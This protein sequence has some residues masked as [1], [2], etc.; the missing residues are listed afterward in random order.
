MSRIFVEVG[1][2]TYIHFV[3]DIAWGKLGIY[4]FRKK[5]GIGI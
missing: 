5:I 1:G 4:I 2:S 3:I